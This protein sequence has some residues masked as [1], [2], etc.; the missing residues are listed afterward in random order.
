MYFIDIGAYNG[1]T[2]S[3]TFLLEKLIIGKEYVQ[4]HYHTLLKN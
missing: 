2:F 1:R 4:N 3:N